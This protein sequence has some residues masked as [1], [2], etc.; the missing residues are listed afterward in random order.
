MNLDPESQNLL[1]MG[2]L[3]VKNELTGRT[4]LAFLERVDA[5]HEKGLPSGAKTG[6]PSVDSHYTVCP[7]QMTILTGWPGSGKSEWLD[8]LL[9][10]LARQGWRLCLFSPENQPNEIHVVK[11]LE[12]FVGKPFG[13]GPTERMTKEE[14][15]E[16]ATEIDQWFSFI[17]PAFTSEKLSFTI[18]EVLDAAE[19]DFRKR[20]LWQSK[21]HFLGL[22][23]DPWNELEHLRPQGLSETE[24]VSQTLSLIRNWA[25]KHNVHVWVVAHP[26]KLKRLENGKLPVPTPDTISGSQ[27]WWNKADACITVWREF[28]ETPSQSVE[29]HVQKVRFK[30]IGRQGM[31][32]LLYDR[33]TGRYHEPVVTPVE[34][35][36]KV[37]GVDF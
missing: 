5:L 8:A 24:Y 16:A 13:A 14:A 17:T 10:N 36:R 27:H 6:W 1:R 19:F 9:L 34:V 28:G 4:A 26:Q 12:K 22:V 32:Q 25:R 2:E 11:F 3:V 23:I 21:E 15:A 30:H 7:G 33:I 31:V 37:V 20:D 29:I 18:Q 35:K